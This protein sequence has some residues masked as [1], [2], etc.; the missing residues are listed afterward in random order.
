M[1]GGYLDK[2]ADSNGNCNLARMMGMQK[3]DAYPLL[4]MHKKVTGRA[5]DVKEKLKKAVTKV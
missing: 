5:E 2:G 3:F 1:Y 4:K